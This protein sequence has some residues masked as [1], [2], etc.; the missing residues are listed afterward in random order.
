MYKYTC[1]DVLREQLYFKLPTKLGAGRASMP[2][3]YVWKLNKSPAAGTAAALS[4][5]HTGLLKV[6]T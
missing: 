2:S 1:S 4:P 5:V 3:D 6:S